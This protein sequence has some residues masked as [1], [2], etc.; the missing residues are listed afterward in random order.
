MPTVLRKL[1]YSDVL[2]AI[3]LAAQTAYDI[4]FAMFTEHCRRE[5]AFMERNDA[6]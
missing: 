5:K 4:A 6:D 1:S 3:P 2:A